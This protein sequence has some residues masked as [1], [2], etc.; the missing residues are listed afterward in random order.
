MKHF[1]RYSFFLLFV[2]IFSCNR[3]D[4]I[5]KEFTNTDPIDIEFFNRSS[6]SGQVFD[7]NNLPLSNVEIKYYNEKSIEETIISD[8]NGIF[9]IENKPL[10]EKGQLLTFEKSNHFKQYATV[11]PKPNKLSFL[12]IFQQK[13]EG[14]K[15]IDPKI[16]NKLS[17][18]QNQINCTIPKNI[19][20]DKNRNQYNN[21]VNF[22]IKAPYLEE[23]FVFLDPGF[24]IPSSDFGQT[25]GGDETS[26]APVFSFLVEFENQN[27]SQLDIDNPLNIEVQLDFSLFSNY[28]NLFLWHFDNTTGHWIEKSEIDLSSSFPNLT[29]EID[30]SGYYILSE[31]Y[32]IKSEFS[33]FVYYSDGTPAKNTLIELMTHDSISIFTYE[34]SITDADG[35]YYFNHQNNEELILRVYGCDFSVFSDF[36]PDIQSSIIEDIILEQNFK[37]KYNLTINSF[38]NSIEKGFAE[39]LDYQ[40]FSPY[41]DI[42]PI[43]NDSSEIN[44]SFYSCEP[45][46]VFYNLD[47]LPIVK[48]SLPIVVSNNQNYNPNDYSIDYN[49]EQYLYADINNNQENIFDTNVFQFLEDNNNQVYNISSSLNDNFSALR[50]TKGENLCHFSYFKF[51]DEIDYDLYESTDDNPLQLEII[52]EDN[53]TISGHFYG[54]LNHNGQDKYI[55][56]YFKAYK[57]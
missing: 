39:I 54:N 47:Y 27:G 23:N 30:K 44:F 38:G 25:I 1:K 8:E 29:F 21:E 36:T 7:E 6:I 5:E 2:L 14:G 51:N 55:D 3:E 4:V 57:Y 17:Y 34:A 56:G 50:F 42:Y 10:K 19:F 41:I 52:S 12:N 37:E 11:K 49:V 40:S 15:I 13:K 22:F 28:E 9:K 20:K 18:Y 48:S 53:F 45:Y 32:S 26:V 43:I 24:G 46:L 35:K 33:G 16:Q 31:K